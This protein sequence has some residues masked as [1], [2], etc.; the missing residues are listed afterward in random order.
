MCIIPKS[1][2]LDSMNE[3]SFIVYIYSPPID[4]NKLWIAEHIC[5]S[6]L[7]MFEN[8]MFWMNKLY[9]SQ[10]NAHLFRLTKTQSVIVEL[11][12]ADYPLKSIDNE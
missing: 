2:V 11:I 6:S 3:T 4:Y 8:T 10:R 1:F 7:I 12:T 9:T 5:L